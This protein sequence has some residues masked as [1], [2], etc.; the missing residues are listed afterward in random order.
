MIQVRFERRYR[1]K[2]TRTEAIVTEERW[3]PPGKV[4]KVARYIYM[5]YPPTKR[6]ALLSLNRWIYPVPITQEEF[7]DFTSP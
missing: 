5:N 3:V 7:D 2:P 4:I 1:Y 6:W